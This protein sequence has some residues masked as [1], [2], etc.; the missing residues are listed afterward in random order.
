MSSQS[1]TTIVSNYKKENMETFRKIV[2]DA[3][4]HATQMGHEG[5]KHRDEVIRIV[6]DKL[7]DIH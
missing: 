7:K 4:I 6:T 5:E 1:I 2:K 3:R